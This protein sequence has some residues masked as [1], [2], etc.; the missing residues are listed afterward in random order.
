MFIQTL[1][2]RGD[3]DGNVGMIVVQYFDAFGRGNQAKKLNFAHSPMFQN[4]DCGAG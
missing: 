3:M 2:N 1:V 4:V